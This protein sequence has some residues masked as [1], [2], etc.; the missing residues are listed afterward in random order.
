MKEYQIN[1]KH[2][3]YAVFILI[4]I[5]ALTAAG[6]N[7]AGDRDRDN[8][9]VV[10]G[11]PA[12][13]D[14][15]APKPTEAPEPTDTPTPTAPTMPTG[16]D[17]GLPSPTPF[18]WTTPM[19]T[20]IPTP[21]PTPDVGI[22]YPDAV[23]P[24]LT[25]RFT[26]VTGIP[27][28]AVQDIKG[29]Y[30]AETFPRIDGSTATIPISEAIY[31]YATGED[32]E[33]AAAA[34]KHTKTS[35]S[36]YGLFN[37]DS[38][39]LIVYEPSDAVID[40]FDEHPVIMKPIGLDA[41]VFMT[42]TDNPVES[43]TMGQLQRIYTGEISSWER[44]GGPQKHIYAF[45]RP[46]GTGSQNLIKK[47]LMGELEMCDPDNGI[48]DG[49]EDILEGLLAYNGQNSA[50]GYSVFYYANNMYYIP[51]LRYMAIDGV[52]PSVETIYS[53]EYKLV[54]P[55]YAVIRADEPEDSAAHIF[56]DWLTGDA[57]QQIIL[58]LG[59]V[60]VNM[61]EN[62]VFPEVDKNYVKNPV[63]VFDPEPLNPG[64]YFV[65]YYKIG[66][67][68]I[69]TGN[70][71]I[72][73]DKW[74]QIMTFYSVFIPEECRGRIDFDRIVVT[75][76]RTEDYGYGAYLA[77][78]YGIFDLKER[79]YVREPDRTELE[80]LGV[81]PMI[82]RRGTNSWYG[83]FE[84]TVIDSDYNVLMTPEYSKQYES[85]TPDYTTE[86]SLDDYD[87][88]GLD[89]SDHIFR[90]QNGYAEVYYEM[91]R[92]DYYSYHSRHNVD[93]MLSEWGRK[94][95]RYDAEEGIFWWQIPTHVTVFDRSFNP[96]EYLDAESFFEKYEDSFIRYVNS[97]R[98]QYYYW[99][100][101]VL[102]YD[103]DYII[104][105]EISKDAFNN[106]PCTEWHY[107]DYVQKREGDYECV[108]DA[109]GKM[110]LRVLNGALHDD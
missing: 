11:T 108:Y 76:Q 25:T 66:G 10:S 89:S 9:N 52:M 34:I 94:C 110:I 1:K 39:L 107:G 74:E 96:V 24:D 55:F 49:M 95:T 97:D 38:D 20:R 31:M 73:N 30:S 101:R 86:T 54:N 19:P 51:E 3:S 32:S 75:Q 85:H 100:D 87:G 56:F 26:T 79:A 70:A 8:V 78:Y 14:T 98:Y 28:D 48:Y 82:L 47:V 71:I 17:T 83:S 65:Y 42:N 40:M 45:Q 46:E 27:A 104:I 2:F 69:D 81:N 16:A 50:L 77:N 68:S 72:Y 36:Y 102:V 12:P 7:K 6:C 105:S 44:V 61:P 4:M 90:M 103:P 53:G 23:M 15:P 106:A 99:S 92:S 60:P 13:T 22:I 64:E 18:L 67:D 57:A 109:E 59:Y 88:H 41:L 29:K 80:L 5:V 63:E 35:K 84:Y 58:D 91:Y 93:K 43:V 21:T 33:A 62:A 37:G